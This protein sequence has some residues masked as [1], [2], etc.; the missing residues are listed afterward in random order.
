M[1][2]PTLF[3]ALS[4]I[5]QLASIWANGPGGHSLVGWFCLIAGL[6]RITDRCHSQKDWPAFY[7]FFLQS[8][9]V[10]CIIMSL[11]YLRGF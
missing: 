4:G 11:I 10:G 3:I 8:M 2:L 9:I 7:S 1:G 5:L 6:V